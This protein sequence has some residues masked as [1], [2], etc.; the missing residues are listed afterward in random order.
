MARNINKKLTKEML[1]EMGFCS[2]LWDYETENWKIT[3]H[4]YRK[5]SKEKEYKVI[6]IADAVCKHKYTFDKSYPILVF[7][8]K[9]VN[10]TYS[11]ARFIYAW[12]HGEVKEGE[13][14][15]HKNNNP[16][17]NSLS[18]LQVLSQKENLHKRYK[19]NPNNNRNQWD[20]IHKDPFKNELLTKYHEAQSELVTLTNKLSET[21]ENQEEALNVIN[22]VIDN[23]KG[24]I[25]RE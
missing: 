13:V 11:L 9:G 5:N 25:N 1:V 8:Y 21:K 18:N 15:D 10:Q 19:D 3:R 14:I 6:K 12:F 7:G 17:D 22:S 20:A 23:I 2:V 24:Y 4:W 16:Y